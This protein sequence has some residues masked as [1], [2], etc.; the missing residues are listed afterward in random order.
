MGEAPSI[1]VRRSS[2]LVR[3]VYPKDSFIYNIYFTAYFTALVFVYL[4]ALYVVPGKLS[5]QG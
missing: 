4:I 1:F 5:S 2:G 3:E